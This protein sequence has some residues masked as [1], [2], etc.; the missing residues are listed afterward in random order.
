[1]AAIEGVLEGMQLFLGPQS[2]AFEN[3]FAQYCG[4]EY[5]VG[6]SSGTD[7]L[8]LA[9]R[10]C[11]IGNGDVQDGWPSSKRRVLNWWK[12]RQYSVI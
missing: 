2:Q 3:E 5:G 10:A 6:V 4:C 11:D 7:A 1:M 9:L 12:R 8:T